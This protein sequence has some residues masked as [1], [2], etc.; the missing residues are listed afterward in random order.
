MTIGPLVAGG[1][2]ALFAR[3]GAGTSY[4]TTV[5]PAGI[6]LGLGLALTVP[7]LTTTALGAVSSD[8]AGIASAVNNY[9][10]RLASLA[11][12]AV[13]PALAG[14]STTGSTVGAA[15][16]SSGYRVAMLMCSG[17]CV[18]ASAVSFATIREPRRRDALASGFCCPITGPPARVSPEA[19]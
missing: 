16:F 7:A 2:M 5:L 9:V 17:L 4:V 8:R 13:V 15:A 6:V 14:I 11:A 19:H 1:G 12:V 3:I 10:A 18:V